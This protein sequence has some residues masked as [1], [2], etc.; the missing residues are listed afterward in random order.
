V[1][2][3]VITT[4]EEFARVRK[5]TSMISNI[6]VGGR[7]LPAQSSRSLLFV[8]LVPQP[9]VRVSS[10]SLLPRSLHYCSHSLASLSPSLY[11]HS[12]RAGG[13]PP[14]LYILHTQRCGSAKRVTKRVHQ[15]AVHAGGPRPGQQLDCFAD[16]GT[17]RGARTARQA[18]RGTRAPSGDAG[19][20][21]QSTTTPRPRT[22]VRMT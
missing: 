14:T 5:H 13:A 10:P 16:Y 15:R 4:M 7:C 3:C 20:R 21:T 19:H 2:P 8:C 9:P 1:C 22:C 12:P 6:L 11:I 18:L 17:H